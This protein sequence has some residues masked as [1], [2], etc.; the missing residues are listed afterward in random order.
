MLLRI[1]CILFIALVAGAIDTLKVDAF[2]PPSIRSRHVPFIRKGNHGSLHSLA[3]SKDAL[4]FTPVFSFEENATVSKFDRIDDVIMGGVSTSTLMD[5]TNEPFAKWFGM[6]RTTGG[7]F[8]G[9]R[10]LPFENSLDV[11]DADGF[12]LT[13]RLKSDNEPE[14]RA[15]KL[16]TRIKPDRGEQLYQARFDFLQV[17]DEWSTIPVP[18]SRFQLVRGARSVPDSPPLN[19]TSG[20]YQIGMTMSKFAIGKNMTEVENF[21]DGFFELQIKEIG[22]YREQSSPVP[23]SVTVPKVFTLEEAKKRAPVLLKLLRPVGLLFFTEAS[24][25]RKVAMKLLRTKRKM[26]RG[27]AMLFGLRSRAASSGWTSSLAKMVAILFADGM[28]SIGLVALR[29]SVIYPVRVVR[30]AMKLVQG[31]TKPR[32]QTQS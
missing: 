22:V 15:W 30:K 25:R 26:S 32:L 6:C 27:Q 23:D 4:T 7:G 31:I 1:R 5:V 19:A 21:R 11:G 3:S 2:A 20:I 17:E 12:Y 28:R 9:I 8:C 24:Q 13:C 14:R 16:S 18:F 10:T 29:I